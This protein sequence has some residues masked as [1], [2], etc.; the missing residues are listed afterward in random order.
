MNDTDLKHNL[1]FV[2]KKNRLDEYKINRVFNDLITLQKEFERVK[3][4][5]LKELYLNTKTE[6]KRAFIVQS[7]L[8][9]GF[10][11]R[12]IITILEISNSNVY[13]LKSVTATKDYNFRSLVIKIIK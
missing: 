8:E 6:N 5:K 11:N 4:S 9:K 12:Q 2:M 7:L 1:L 10:S 13:R 3:G